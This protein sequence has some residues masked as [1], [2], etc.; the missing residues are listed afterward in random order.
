MI[1]N[2]E[3]LAVL[4]RE[5]VINHRIYQMDLDDLKSQLNAIIERNW[6]GAA[7]IS[8][9]PYETLFPYENIKFK[10]GRLLRYYLVT[11]EDGALLIYGDVELSEKAQS[12]RALFPTAMGFSINSIGR[13]D[14]KEGK[15]FIHV[16]ELRGFDFVTLRPVDPSAFTDK[17]INKE[18]PDDLSRNG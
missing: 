7:A 6:I 15:I 1:L 13:F 14:R 17:E 4:N 12:L 3:P 16:I 2:R 10:A 11:Q 8:Q 5:T 9:V 18:M